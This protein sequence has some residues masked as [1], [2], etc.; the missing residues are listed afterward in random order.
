MLFWK[1][2]RG[3]CFALCLAL[4]LSALAQTSTPDYDEWSKVAQRAE[5]AVENGRAS[6]NALEALRSQVVEWREQFLKAQTANQARITTW[7]RKF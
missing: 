1:I 5:I 2:F 3:L 6:S 7:N 4:P